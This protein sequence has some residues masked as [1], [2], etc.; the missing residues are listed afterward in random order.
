MQL[1]ATIFSICFGKFFKIKLVIIKQQIYLF[2]L[3]MPPYNISS[4]TN[5]VKQYESY[6]LYFKVLS[7]IIILFWN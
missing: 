5:S 4:W 7:K 3:P 1:V 6:R 2:E